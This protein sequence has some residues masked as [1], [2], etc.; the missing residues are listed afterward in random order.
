MLMSIRKRKRTWKDRREKRF[1]EENKVVIEW[2]NY[3]DPK[4]N[5]AIYAFTM[6]ISIGGSKIL[7]DVNFPVDTLFVITL[8]LSRSSQIITL[9]AKVKWVNPVYDGGLYEVGLEFIHEQPQTIAGFFKH[10]YG[11]D[12]P[13]NFAAKLIEIESKTVISA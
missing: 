7:T 5:D 8:T 3:K 1:E 6:D 9:P 11:K 4:R 12:L 13:E 10:L 2:A